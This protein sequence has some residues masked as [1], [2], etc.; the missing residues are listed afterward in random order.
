MIRWM[1][2]RDFPELNF[3]LFLNPME[4]EEGK[5]YRHPGRHRQWALGRVAAKVLLQRCIREMGENPR[6]PL[7]IR[8]HRTEDG[9]PD[10]LDAQGKSLPVSLSITHSA[11]RVFCAVC[12]AAE[13]TVGADMEWVEPRSDPF[14]MDYYT[15][16]ER[17]DFQSLEDENQKKCAINILWCVKEAVLKA[18]H[19]GLRVD[20]QQ[21]EVT[22]LDW[23]SQK[24]WRT[25]E[26][27]LQNG[28]VPE[29]H[30][31]LAENDT[32]ALAVV[33]IPNGGDAWTM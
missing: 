27:K 14:L 26:V 4:E 7:E 2:A 5:R 25:A 6:S 19:T 20:P 32:L 21:I 1:M 12:P 8:V 33:R 16:R 9:W 29:V 24:A 11:D 28:V 30:W 3:G 23:S 31:C 18:I 22:S 13:G 15:K 10:P 17:E